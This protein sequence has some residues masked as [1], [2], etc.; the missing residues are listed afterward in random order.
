M[1]ISVATYD[2]LIQD[3]IT[4]ISTFVYTWTGRTPNI[5]TDQVE[6]SET[7]NGTGGQ[8]LYL[9]NNPIV[10]VSSLK[11]S[12][13]LIAVSSA[14]GTPGYFIDDTKKFLQIRQGG[15]AGT[16]Q[17]I[18]FG[19]GWGFWPGNGNVEITYTAGYDS[20]P[21]DLDVTVLKMCSTIYLRR[22]REDQAGQAIPQAGTTSYRSWD[23]GPDVWTVLKTYKRISTT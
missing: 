13:H 7:Y 5:F 14:W 12:G 11:I 20:A 21:E 17:S 23:F 18:N 4:G 15:G 19:S 22:L 8:V 3:V 6:L 16:F 2:D 9:R 10:S 1:N